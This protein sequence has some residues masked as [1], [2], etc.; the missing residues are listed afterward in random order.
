VDGN[1]RRA[2]LQHTQSR[3]AS[4]TSP[5]QRRGPGRGGP[6]PGPRGRGTSELR[7]Q[8][9]KK[10][11]GMAVSSTVD[12]DKVIEIEPPISVKKLSEAMGAKVNALVAMMTFKLDIK[13][14]TI[15]SF[16]SEEE[17]ELV[18]MELDRNVKIVET[19][20]AEEELIESLVE[21]TADI[22]QDMR[23]PVVTFMG[24]VDHGKTTLLD[25][26]RGSDVAITS[27]E[28]GGIT[29]HI[30]AYKITTEQ[31][32]SFVVLDT[33]GHAAFT[34]MRIRGATITDVVVLVVAADDGVMP[35]TEEA[36]AHAKEANVPIVVAVNKCDLPGARPEQVRQQL[37]VKGL[38]SEEWG[39]E[40]GFVDVSAVTGDGLTELM[41]RILLEAEVAELAAK[42]L[43]P[44]SGVVIESRQSAEQ[45][46]VVNALVMDGT[47]R[48]KDQVICGE[49]Y[50]RVR[51]ITDDHGQQVEAA[52]PATPVSM[53]G[54]DKL[55]QPGD[56]FFAVADTKKAKEVIE[57]R[58]RRA[59]TRDLAERTAV[60]IENIGATIAAQAVSEIKVILKADVMGSL[61]PIRASLAEIA[62]DEVRF[63]IIHAA[64]GAI[65]ET[66]VTLAAAS[67]AIIIGFNTVPD[68]TARQI[69]DRTGVEI[70]FYDIIYNLIDEMKLALEGLLKPDEIE[71]VH[72]QAEVR[73]VFKSSKFGN[74]AGCFI[75]DGSVNR[76]SRV[77]LSR[78]GA[79]VHTGGIGSL[80]RVQDD[81][82]EVKA[83]FE[84]GL[85]IS[86]FSD[87]KE[88]DE[89]TFYGIELVKRKL[90]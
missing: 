55:P 8:K 19:K 21:Q 49:S 88:G 76:N 83:G 61:E 23:A 9:R 47:L 89:L 26:L 1:L 29:Q 90:E 16:L 85:T 36:I 17:V 72:G 84:C 13:G 32:Q 35:Q 22:T 59:R 37:A 34:A 18:A 58:Q 15:N 64:L 62:N 42:P 54:L 69:A 56:K 67:S 81:V 77:R 31:G 80:R 79:V 11:T 53:L 27:G 5:G 75:T 38:Q 74:I 44:A 40:V 41:E 25:A 66:D 28:A 6:R 24:H 45:G 10:T 52:G 51:G 4:R 33:P 46:I 78:D 86:N 57:D 50:S 20:E 3:T 48:V 63:N 71:T 65:T 2:A 7:G 39:G 14:K 73:A 87:V 43:A 82:R 70:R 30:G 60:T 12:P 68:A